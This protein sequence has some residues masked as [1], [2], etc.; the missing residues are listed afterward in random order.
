MAFEPVT[1]APASSKRR[2][3]SGRSSAWYSD[4]PSFGSAPAASSVFVSTGSWFRPA[5]P[6]SADTRSVVDGDSGECGC[7]RLATDWSGDAPAASSNAAHA[8]RPSRN[9]G[10][11]TRLECVT[12]TSGGS[13]NGPPARCTHAGSRAMA[14]RSAASSPIAQARMGWPPISVGSSSSR[15][16]ATVGRARVVPPAMSLA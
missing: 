10:N 5:A 14:W 8:R 7:A 9:A 4:S 12:A 16:A 2:V 13:C 11:A 3:H 1:R 15:R 6:Y